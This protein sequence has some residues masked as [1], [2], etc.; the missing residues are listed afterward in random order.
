MARKPVSPTVML[1]IGIVM[2]A[3]SIGMFGLL[4][5]AYREQER[6]AAEYRQTEGTVVTAELR[7]QTRKGKADHWFVDRTYR[8]EVDGRAFES[9][10]SSHTSTSYASREGAQRVVDGNPPGSKIP[11][12]YDP[13]GTSRSSDCSI[14]ASRSIRRRGQVLRGAA[15]LRLARSRDARVCVGM[16]GS[17]KTGL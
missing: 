13:A 10:R 2:L 3:A 4:F 11:V 8:Y 6:A 9:K 1:T 15:A 17:G 7:R 16:T 14:S 12:W 5:G